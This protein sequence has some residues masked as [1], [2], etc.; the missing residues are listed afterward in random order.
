MLRFV[1]QRLLFILV[2][3][4]CIVFVVHW[5]MLLIQG[6]GGLW[7]SGQIAVEQTGAFLLQV[8]K[9]DL[10][11]Y[12]A[13]ARELEVSELLRQTFSASMGLLIISGAVAALIGV[14]LGIFVA[15]TRNRVFA[16]SVLAVTIVGISLPSFFAAMLLQHGVIVYFREFDRR[17]LSV[18]G[19]GW[20]YKH[21]LLPIIVLAARP[22]AYLMRTT[23]IVLK[24]TLE[25]D[26]VR[27]AHSKGLSRR[28]VINVHALRN[29]AVPILTAIGVSWRFSLGILPVVEFMFAWPGMGLRMLEGINSQQISMVVPLAAIFGLTLLLGNLLLDV[30][31]RIIDPRVRGES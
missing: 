24:R 9:G 8:L 30:A 19:F 11:V 2:V 20:D 21:M 26:Y 7:E 15:L 13:D 22:V 23:Y 6:E 25:E 3:V 27:T 4:I 29:V 14:M 16:F 28:Y 18:A 17:L 1:I 31:Y 12:V 10:G 5:G